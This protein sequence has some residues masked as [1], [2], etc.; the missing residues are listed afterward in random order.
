[1]EVIRSGRSPDFGAYAVLFASIY[2][3]EPYLCHQKFPLA[4]LQP[5]FEYTITGPMSGNDRRPVAVTRFLKESFYGEEEWAAGTFGQWC[6]IF[7]RLE[8]WADGIN[9][10]WETVSNVSTFSLFQD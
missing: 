10:S 6:V 8:R 5:A 1:M 7:R 3:S 2:L 4:Y 9:S